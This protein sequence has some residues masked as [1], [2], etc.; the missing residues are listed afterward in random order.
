MEIQGRRIAVTIVNKD[1]SQAAAV[2]ITTAQRFVS[3][4][5][6]RLTSPSLDSKEGVTFGGAT[7]TAQGE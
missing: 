4:K 2:N 7:V 5:A 1:T 6:V 3:V